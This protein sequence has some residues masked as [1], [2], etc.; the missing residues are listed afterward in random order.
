NVSCTWASL[1]APYTVVVS[2]TS[3]PVTEQRLLSATLTI[4]PTK[5]EELSV[6]V[7]SGAPFPR[8]GDY[9]PTQDTLCSFEVKELNVETKSVWGVIN[10][11]AFGPTN[12]QDTCVIG[13]SYFSVE[14]CKR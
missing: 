1:A 11:P 13:P 10:C 12:E 6:L 7:A 14:N 5:T 3:G 2:L 8:N 9:G 4:D